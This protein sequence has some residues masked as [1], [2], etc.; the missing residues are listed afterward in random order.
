MLKHLIAVLTIVNWIEACGPQMKVGKYRCEG[1]YNALFVNQK[2][3][4]A[5]C[6]EFAYDISKSET[7]ATCCNNQLLVFSKDA[8]GQCG[9]YAYDKTD[10]YC[11]DPD[12][13]RLI[14]L[15]EKG[16]IKYCKWLNHRQPY[17]ESREQCCRPIYY[18]GTRRAYEQHYLIPASQS[19]H[20]CGIQYFNPEIHTCC[21]IDGEQ[22]ALH[23]FQHKC[24]THTHWTDPIPAKAAYLFMIDTFSRF[25]LAYP[26]NTSLSATEVARLIHSNVIMSFG[27]PDA[28]SSDNARNLVA[29]HQVQELLK[30]YGIQ[31]VL[32][33][34]YS[35]RS[36][37]QV[38]NANRWVKQLV[39]MLSRQYGKPWT[40]VVSLACFLLN[41]KP[42]KYY[43]HLS[44]ME[45]M[46]VF[47]S[48][49][50]GGRSYLGV[51]V[52][53]SCLSK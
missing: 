6:A 43:D 24:C 35:P 12:R 36:H 25:R 22:R 27:P 14:P 7:G 26:V 23:S 39:V 47:K 48:G 40:E 50:T 34:P 16:D 46:K 51:N 44:P 13:S 42:T 29:S 5:Y 49:E 45:I 4:C 17:L 30:F 18:F 9:Q 21:V 31:P 8:C 20:A 28:I 3:D 53:S 19:C 32:V 38:E 33:S 41:A 10:H 11:M 2:E 37:G 15:S 1:R 52:P